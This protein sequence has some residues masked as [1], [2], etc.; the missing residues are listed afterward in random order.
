V[1]T[2]RTIAAGY[3]VASRTERDRETA[4]PEQVV[5]AAS[6]DGGIIPPVPIRQ[7]I[8]TWQA[9]EFDSR[10]FEGEIRVV[11]DPTGTVQTATIAVPIHSVYDRVIL[12]AAKKWKY[13]PAM[14]DGHAVSY[15][16]PI[17]ISLLP[18]RRLPR[19]DDR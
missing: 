12:E 5:C 4:P 11:I 2:I 1:Q 10:R 16:Q 6:H 19:T 17:A 14:K 13:K 15:C 18:Q 9:V 7:D 3:L 8:P